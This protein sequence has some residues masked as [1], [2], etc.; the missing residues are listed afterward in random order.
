[1]SSEDE[2][3]ELD[4]AE[5]P[6]RLLGV[7]PALSRL[8]QSFAVANAPRQPEYDAPLE[9]VCP[10]APSDDGDA[11]LAGGVTAHEVFRSLVK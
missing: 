2:G 4:A 1:M 9:P 11:E 5:P 3:V 7:G 10:Q 6:T 8:T